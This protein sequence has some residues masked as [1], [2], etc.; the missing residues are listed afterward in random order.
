MDELRQIDSN[1]NLVRAQMLQFAEMS[2]QY[3]WFS[4]EERQ[5]RLAAYNQQLSKLQETKEQ[6]VKPL[7]Q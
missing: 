2:E 3:G 6:L 5:E 4:L 7:N 1:I